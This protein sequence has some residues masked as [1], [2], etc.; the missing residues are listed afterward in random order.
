MVDSVLFLGTGGS[1]GIPVIGCS[2]PVC[3][4]TNLKNNRLRPSILIELNGKF[5]LVDAGPDFREQAL[6]YKINHLDGLIVT[7]AHEDHIGGI[8]DLRIYTIRSNKP[9]PMLLSDVSLEDLKVRFSYIFNNKAQGLVTKF[10]TQVLMDD[11]GDVQFLE[12]EIHY[13]SYG[14]MGMK[15]TGLRIKDFAYVTD[16]CEYPET[17]FDDLKNVRTLVIS[18][19]RNTP[20]H[21]HFTVAQAIAFAQKVGAEKIYFTHIAHEIDHEKTSSLLPQGIQLSYDGLK[22][23]I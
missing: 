4:S 13:F 20:T 21:L 3:T 14:Q 2:C 16:I 10:E 6:R 23:F 7:H 1:M 11:I 8:D 19:L 18:A 12:E 17:I 9:L 5:I 15:V 22:I